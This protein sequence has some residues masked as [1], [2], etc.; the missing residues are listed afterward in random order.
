MTYI[1]TL[2]DKTGVRYI[3]K[4]N[5]PLT[6]FKVH[7]KESKYKRTRKEK[8][9]FSLLNNNEKPILEI[10]DEVE[11]CDWEFF[12]R[13][14]ISQFKSWNFL[15]ING[16]DGGE[17]SNG[18]EGKVHS[19]ETK[20]KLKKISD[21][22]FSVKNNRDELSSKIKLAFEKNPYLNS[23]KVYQYDLDNNFIK[24]TTINQANKELNI[25]KSN[26]TECCKGRRNRAGKYIWKYNKNDEL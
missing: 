18:F 15:I 20:L 17:G 21:T 10:L 24:E 2:S 8:W 25:P 16:T 5:D 14:W 6:R 11:E 19:K 4:S 13:F 12:E 26:I 7:L 3:G 23:K 9:I 22:Y 1:Y